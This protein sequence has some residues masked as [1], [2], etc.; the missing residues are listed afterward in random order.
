[1]D[2]GRIGNGWQIAGIWH[3]RLESA[4][5]QE[6]G[7]FTIDDETITVLHGFDLAIPYNNRRILR[8]LTKITVDLIYPRIELLFVKGESDTDGATAV[9]EIE[10][11]TDS[12]A[13]ILFAANS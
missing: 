7:T 3:H 13:C 10:S 4:H 8:R 2:I 9:D 11:R 5:D 6:T 1:M 12:I